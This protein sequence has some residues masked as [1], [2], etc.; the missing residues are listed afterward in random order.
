MLAYKKLKGCVGRNPR[1]PFVRWRRNQK[2]RGDSVPS[3][4]MLKP[5]AS[6][7]LSRLI[8][9][10]MSSAE[11]MFESNGIGSTGLAAAELRSRALSCWVDASMMMSNSLRVTTCT[12]HVYIIPLFK[13]NS[14]LSPR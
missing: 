8:S 6:L 12:L 7:L 14:I 9:I 5:S 1:T 13:D 3:G 2:L 4:I 10:S 11:A